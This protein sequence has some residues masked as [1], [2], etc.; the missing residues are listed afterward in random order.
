MFVEYGINW[1]NSGC[2]FIGGCCEI[3]PDFIKSLNDKM[4]ELKIKKKNII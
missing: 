3:G 4:I 2:S 1:F